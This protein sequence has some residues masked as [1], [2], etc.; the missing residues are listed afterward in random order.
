MD[1][2]RALYPRCAGVVAEFDPFHRG[3]AHL[4]A[5]VRALCP[6]RGVICVMSGHFTQRGSAAAADKWARAEMALRGG[7][8]LVLELPVLWAAAPA[9][10]FARGAVGIL[11]DT[12]LVDT[13]AFGSECGEISPLARLADALDGAA[14]Q[15]GIRAHLAR[16]LS[17]AAARQAA[18]R[19][20]LG[21]DAELLSGANNNLGV[22]YLR[23]VRHWGGEVRAVTIP[24]QGVA[25][26][27]TRAEG[28]YA[29]ASLLRR[30]LAAGAWGEM[31]PY[32][33]PESLSILR[34]RW[35]DGLC[36]ADLARCE[37]GVLARLRA[38][39]EEELKRLPGWEPGLERRLARAARESVTLAELY[40]RAKTRRC[41]EAR[42]RRMV[43]WAFLGLTR[44]NQRPRAPYLRVLG[45][46]GRGR[47][48]LRAMDGTARLPRLIRPGEARRLDPE[49]RRVFE[50]EARATDLWSLCLP[51]P[52]GRRGGMEWRSRPAVLPEEH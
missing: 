40:D 51:G 11:L 50:I 9:E 43:L 1:S 6:D 47:Q 41:P 38:I 42:V 26:D 5:R 32:L 44:E 39:T 24:R 35:E 46:N 45:C 15:E 52:E 31:T 7:A 20:L 25:H 12:G 16:G 10:T 13:L 17:Y 14:A 48:L 21:A 8:D 34:R 22:E 33:P 4:L 2:H 30:Y 18:M 28:G 27:G 36:P 29:S 19:D 3:H 23:A 37:L 49:G